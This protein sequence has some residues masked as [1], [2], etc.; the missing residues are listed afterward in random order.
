AYTNGKTTTVSVY[1]FDTI[2]LSKNWLLNGGVRIDDYKTET[3]AKTVVNTD[4]TARGYN[5]NFFPGYANGA[6]AP[7]SKS[8][9]DTLVSWKL[10]AVYKPVS[11]GS[12]YAATANSYL[13]PGG[14]NFSLSATPVGINSAGFKPQQTRSVEVGTKWELLNKRL[15]VSAAAYRTTAKNE[16]AFDDQN[17]NATVPGEDRE[18]KGIELDA[19]GQ[20]TD[21]RQVSAG[22]ATMDTEI[23]AGSARENSNPSTS[24]TGVGTRWSP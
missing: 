4:P 8:D 21:N 16:L 15:S 10:G 18:I 13:P 22:I 12:I 24:A 11:N 20:L 14:S 7:T 1:A 19:V 3:S 5:G 17:G 9:S 6:L 23:K 2:E